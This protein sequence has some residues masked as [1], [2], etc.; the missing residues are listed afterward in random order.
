MFQITDINEARERWSK[1]FDAAIHSSIQALA[2]F[3]RQ[4]L[5]RLD[6]LIAHANYPINTGRLKGAITKS[7]L[8]NAMLT[9]FVISISF[10]PIS[11]SSLYQ[12]VLYTQIYEEPLFLQCSFYFAQ[13]LANAMSIS[14]NI[15]LF[16][17]AL[18]CSFPLLPV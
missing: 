18:G 7:K 15:H 5:K 3:G 16:A 17:R 1:W 11:V 13:F 6:G 8:R 9:V 14:A 12:R 4:K 10:S 2:K